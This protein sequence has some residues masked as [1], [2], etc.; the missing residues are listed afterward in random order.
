MLYIH[1]DK[2]QIKSTNNPNRKYTLL[3]TILLAVIHTHIICLLKFFLLKSL[4]ANK[5][6][7][8]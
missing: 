3:L 1:V 7:K 8:I 5:I 6:S 2:F 4:R